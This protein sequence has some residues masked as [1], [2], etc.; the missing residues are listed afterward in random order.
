MQQRDLP[1]GGPYSLVQVSRTE[2]CLHQPPSFA[3]VYETNVRSFL[4]DVCFID[5]RKRGFGKGSLELNVYQLTAQKGACI[6]F[7][8]PS[9]VIAKGTH[10]NCHLLTLY[11]QS[12]E[13][14]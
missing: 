4:K 9:I 1:F 6:N 10:V 11:S 5:A 7:P 3:R 14:S 13:D 8:L 2:G 12:D